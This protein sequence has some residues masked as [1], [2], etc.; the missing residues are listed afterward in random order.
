MITVNQDKLTQLK[1]DH[2]KSEAKAL[3][4]AS[5]WSELPGAV[6]QLQNATEWKEYR[7]EIRNFIINPIENPIWPQKPE[8]VWKR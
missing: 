1:K 5:D 8:T 3:L 4:S 7:K 6:E 2:C